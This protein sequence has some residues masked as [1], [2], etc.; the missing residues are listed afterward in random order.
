MVIFG[1]RGAPDVDLRTFRAVDVGG[2]LAAG[3]TADSFDCAS[4]DRAKRGSAQDDTLSE[5]ELLHGGPSS[6][7]DI[8]TQET[9]LA[10][11]PLLLS[12]KLLLG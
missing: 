9:F 2:L 4:R 10:L 6:W 12:R 8:L 7:E 3:T 5:G 11:G 1:E